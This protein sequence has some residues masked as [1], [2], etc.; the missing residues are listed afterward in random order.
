MRVLLDTHS[1]LWYITDDDQ[2]SARA[3]EV[4][5]AADNEVLL[6]VGS[7]W[8]I[9]IKNGLG[10]LALEHPFGDLMSQQLA[11]NDIETLHIS[12][13]HLTLYAELPLHHRDPFDRLIISQARSESIPVVGKDAAFGDYG[14]EVWW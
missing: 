9:A 8:E 2:L 6:S 5:S 11:V 1:F 14:V 7:L 13:S 3:E 4:I 12:L 10:K